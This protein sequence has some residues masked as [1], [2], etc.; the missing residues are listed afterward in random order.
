MDAFGTELECNTNVVVN[1]YALG[2]DFDVPET[3]GAQ[4][5]CRRFRN[6]KCRYVLVFGQP[7]WF[8][9][10]ASCY[11]HR[12]WNLV[13]PNLAGNLVN[14]RYD[15]SFPG[16]AMSEKRAGIDLIDDHVGMAGVFTEVLSRLSV[17][18]KA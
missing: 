5:I 1:L 18:A 17:H 4:R 6:R 15:W 13:E 12:P 16:V 2:C 14:K 10:V 9:D 3:V 7:S 8:K 11:G